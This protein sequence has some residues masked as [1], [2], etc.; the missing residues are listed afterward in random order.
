M[1]C[2]KDISVESVEPKSL[3]ELLRM[4]VFFSHQGADSVADGGKGDKDNAI[5]VHPQ[6][7]QHSEPQSQQHSE[8]Q[9][10]QGSQL[11]GTAVCLCAY[12]LKNYKGTS[13]ICICTCMY[14]VGMKKFDSTS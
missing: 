2:C 9:S 12:L 6:S 8:L 7:H 5:K 1:H 4:L 14:S 13:N 3:C 11:Q 10:Q